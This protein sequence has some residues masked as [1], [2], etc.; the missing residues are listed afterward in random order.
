MTTVVS[1]IASIQSC[2]SMVGTSSSQHCFPKV[3]LSSI[4]RAT[5]SISTILVDSP[6]HSSPSSFSPPHPITISLVPYIFQDDIPSVCMTLP[7][8]EYLPKSYSFTSY[9]YLYFFSCEY[10]PYQ[11]RHSF[12]PNPN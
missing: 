8:K 5:I 4:I 9:F 12:K 1:Y 3:N 6:I 7:Q 11:H 10:C 2:C